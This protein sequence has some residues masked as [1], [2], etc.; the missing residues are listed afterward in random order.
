MALHDQ[1]QRTLTKQRHIDEFSYAA[2]SWPHERRVIDGEPD[3]R[4]QYLTD[5]ERA[6]NDQFTPC[7]SRARGAMLALDL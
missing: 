3:H 6:R 5:D 1:Y 4:D 7:C 2:Q